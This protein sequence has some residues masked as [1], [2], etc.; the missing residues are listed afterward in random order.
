MG[1]P[2]KQFSK[3]L[4][5]HDVTQ[6]ILA[7]VGY[8]YIRFVWMT[9]RFDTPHLGH[10]SILSDPHARVIVAFWHGRMVMLPCAWSWE[11]SVFMLLSQH[12]DGLLISRVLK[13]F[14]IGSIFGSTTRG[15]APAARDIISALNNG[16]VVGITPDGPKGPRH[17]C[18]KGVIHLAHL[19]AKDKTCAAQTC[20]II[21]TS[22]FIKRHRIL[23]SWD[24]FM[25]PLPF[26][27]GEIITGEPL[28]ITATMTADDL[29]VQRDVLEAR[30]NACMRS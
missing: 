15:G 17:V 29:E 10:E 2:L 30:L 13:Y 14:G 18:K 19:S 23:G 24:R 27:S 5:R 8:I 22:Y 26:S 16:H 25:F 6:A 9:C 21:P 3:K 1:L 7:W 28:A 12:R 4:L 11:R 20:W